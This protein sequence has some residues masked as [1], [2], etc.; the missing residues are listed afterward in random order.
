MERIIDKNSENL[1]LAVIEYICLTLASGLLADADRS[2]LQSQIDAI[3][4]IK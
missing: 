4:I 3:I 2:D 1:D